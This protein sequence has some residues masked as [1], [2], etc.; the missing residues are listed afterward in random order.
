MAAPVSV[1]LDDTTRELLQREARDRKIGLSALLREIAT[2]AAKETRR[3]RI[4]QQTQALAE[5]IAT[6][7]EAKEFFE[8]WGTPTAELPE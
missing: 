3:R 6:H 1:R 5:H 8:F 7:P 2:E 4:R